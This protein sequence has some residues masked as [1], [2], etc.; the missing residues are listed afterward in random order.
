MYCTY[1]YQNIHI[2][3]LIIFPP[4]RNVLCVRVGMFFEVLGGIGAV[5]SHH[6]ASSSIYVHV[7]TYS[8]RAVVD[9]T[10][11]NVIVTIIITIVITIIITADI[12]II[13]I[14]I[15]VVV[16]ANAVVIV[17]DYAAAV[18]IRIQSVG[19]AVTAAAVSIADRICCDTAV[20]T[21]VVSIVIIRAA[22]HAVTVI[23]TV[24]VIAACIVIQI[25]R[26]LDRYAAALI[27]NIR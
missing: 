11:N 15:V 21:V 2:I 19:V 24:T 1:S 23:V 22:G 5:D 8:V 17:R 4:F 14:T 27:D 7:S 9:N 6:T 13:I 25:T 3:T 26:I 20:P 16:V 18:Y 12:I 10:T